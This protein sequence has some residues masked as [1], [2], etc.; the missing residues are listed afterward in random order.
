[1]LWSVPRSSFVETNADQGIRRVLEMK[2]LLAFLIIF[3]ASTSAHSATRRLATDCSFVSTFTPSEAQ[4]FELDWCTVM[5][6]DDI[7]GLLK[8]VAAKWGAVYVRAPSKTVTVQAD[9]TEWATAVA[10][11]PIKSFVFL[12]ARSATNKLTIKHVPSRA[13]EFMTLKYSCT[14]DPVGSGPTDQIQRKNVLWA[15]LNFS[16]VKIGGENLALTVVGTH[17]GL[18]NAGERRCGA[19]PPSPT[20][21]LNVGLVDLRVFDGSVPVLVDLRFNTRN[22]EVYSAYFL[23]GQ[24]VGQTASRVK[25]VN[26]AGSHWNTGGVFVNG[27]VQNLWFDPVNTVISDPYV[28]GYGWDGA[29]A[30]SAGGRKVGC[31]DLARSANGR[32]HNSGPYFTDSLRGGITFEYGYLVFSPN[33]PIGSVGTSPTDPFIVR[34]KDWG[35]SGPGTGYPEGVQIKN[36]SDPIFF[37]GDPHPAYGKTSPFRFIRFVGLPSTYGNGVYGGSLT[38]CAAGNSSNNNYPDATGNVIRFEANDNDGETFGWDATFEGEW[39]NRWLRGAL[40][41]LTYGPWSDVDRSWGHTLRAGS[42][43]TFSDTVALHD[44]NIATGA[45]T[46]TNIKIQAECIYSGAIWCGKG[47]VSAKDNS[48]VDTNVSG[49][50]TIEPSSG[51]T[52]IRDVNFTGSSRDVINVGAG[53]TV[54]VS[55]VCAAAGSRII[56]SGTARYNGVTIALPFVLPAVSDC[57]SPMPAPPIDVSVT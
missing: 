17:P 26:V 19:Y 54:N 32:G 24:A 53:S 48:I 45:G 39:T 15:F 14:P 37:K 23:G 13:L 10:G 50:V 16:Y 8:D 46:Y 40:V 31:F 36:S 25:Q 33:A 2:S 22:A 12:E 29:V 11:N 35:S 38:N 4:P 41:L 3:L 43:F 7:S 30:G 6:D 57:S 42:G 52:T 21:E 28:R 56:G 49:I 55:N 20:R 34:V 44:T 47:K 18:G 5:D 51:I 9:T 1:M 27:G